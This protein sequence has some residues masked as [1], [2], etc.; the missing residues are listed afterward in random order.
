MA[1]FAPAIYERP[2]LEGDRRRQIVQ[3][4]GAALDAVDPAQA[5]LRVLRTEGDTLWVQQRTPTPGS[6]NTGGRA[7]P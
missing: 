7:Q 3:V 5:V 6:P 4:L 2:G 1:T